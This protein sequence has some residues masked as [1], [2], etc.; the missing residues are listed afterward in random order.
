MRGGFSS[1]SRNRGPGPPR[2]KSFVRARPSL[3]LVLIVLAACGARAADPPF[4]STQ[5]L[6]GAIRLIHQNIDR[7]PRYTC[8]QTIYRNRYIPARS[9]KNC[10]EVLQAATLEDFRLASSDRIRLDVSATG[11]GEIFSWAGAKAFQSDRMADV[12]GGGLS[13]SGDF[14]AFLVSI[15]AADSVLYQYLGAIEAGGRRYAEYT[16]SIPESTSHYRVQTGRDPHDEKVVPYQGRFLIDRDN[17]ELKSLTVR[18]NPPPAEIKACGVETRI[19]Y[20]RVA[21]GSARFL[22][23]EQT[24]LIENS[25]TGARSENRVE[26]DACHEFRSE[27]VFLA[28]EEEPPSPAL[29]SNASAGFPEL[30]AGLKLQIRLTTAIDPASAFAGDPIEGVLAKAVPL[31]HTRYVL[32][33]KTRVYG[34]LMTCRE[35]FLPQFSFVLG[36]RWDSIETPAGRKPLTLAPLRNYRHGVAGETRPGTGAYLFDDARLGRDAGFTADWRVAEKRE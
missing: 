21:I 32:P 16:Y 15:F 2:T 23:P 17:L 19:V 36:I 4:D 8:R 26:Y 3:R 9:F 11:E 34:R 29:S 28:S 5:L 13:S 35:D 12:I 18:M 14:D 6:R 24:L 31:P 33:E 10:G 22:L 20:R 27:S 1:S 7:A 30:P 25:T